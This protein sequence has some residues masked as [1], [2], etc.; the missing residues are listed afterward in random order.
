MLRKT[1]FA[2]VLCTSPMLYAASDLDNLKNISQDQFRGIAEDLGAA[3]SYKALAPAE[4][5]GTTGFDIGVEVTAT[6]LQSTQAWKDAT[7]DS[8]DYLPVP[9]VHVHKGL[10]FNIDLGAFFAMVPG[11][12][13]KLYGGEVRYSYLSGNAAMPALAVRGTYTRLGGID[14]LDFHSTS[15]EATLSKGFLM[16]T[17]YAG[18]GQVWSVSTPHVEAPFSLNEES[19]SQTRFFAGVNVNLGITNFAIEADKTGDAASYGAKVGF[20]F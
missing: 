18:V 11:T 3:L 8:M 15:L 2:A 12:D 7:G 9:K 4:P 14:E 20:R 17:P 16:F 6:K 1:L 19:I 10:P 5:L 13:M